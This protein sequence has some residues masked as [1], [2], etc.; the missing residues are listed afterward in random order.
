MD[1]YLFH[2][3][4]IKPHMF[5]VGILTVLQGI[6]II[7]QAI[8]LAKA[9]TYMFNGTAPSAV[10]PF[11]TGFIIAY[12]LRHFI[13]WLKERLAYRFAENTASVVQE[14]LIRKLFELGPRG[15]GKSGSGNMIT[16]ALEGI[17]NFRTYLELFIPRAISMMVIPIAVLIYVFAFDT[18]SGIVL[19]SHD[20]HSYRFLNSFRISCAEIR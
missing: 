13:Q 10:L 16:L 3:K 6:A 20:A 14:N 15:I 2:Y 19:S 7:V 8:F 17:P 9:I 5:I 1:K 4:G 12:F 11:F 18:I